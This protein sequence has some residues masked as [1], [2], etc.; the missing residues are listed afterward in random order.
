MCARIDD[1]PEP[2]VNLVALPPPNCSGIHTWTGSPV[3][4]RGQPPG[5]AFAPLVAGPR[6]PACPPRATPPS[7][8]GTHVPGGYVPLVPAV[9]AAIAAVA[10][11]VYVAFRRV[12]R[13]G[14]PD[15][16]RVLRRADDSTSMDR[17]TGAVRSVQSAEVVLPAARIDAL[18]SPLYLERL[19]RTY[20]RFLT[21]ATLG[22]VRVYYTDRERF[23]CLLFRRFKLLTFHAPEYEMDATRGVVRWRI[24]SGVLVAR[25]GRQGDGYLEIDV[26][27]RPAG[28]PGEVVVH[29]EVEVANFFPA[30]ASTIGR[31]FYATTQSRIH[32]LVTRGFLRSLARLDLA[33]SKV[34]RFATVDQVPDPR[35]PP[36]RDLVRVPPPTLSRTARR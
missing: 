30:I 29:V 2:A 33:V 4:P 34:G 11:G 19:A 15:W 13:S 1:R 18:W 35:M 12:V 28:T 8:V 36:P 31:W 27:R 7:R 23:V 16:V 10:A 3:Q 24:A 5:A 9:A 17:R 20:W 14:V 32:V 26:R 6:R 21:R 22:L 25:R